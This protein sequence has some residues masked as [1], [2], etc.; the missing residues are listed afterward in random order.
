MMLSRYCSP[1]GSCGLGFTPV[2]SGSRGANSEVNR[3]MQQ[4]QDEYAA[5]FCGLLERA[6]VPYHILELYIP[7]SIG[8]ALPWYDLIVTFPVGVGEPGVMINGF[9]ND[10]LVPPEQ[11]FK[12]KF[13]G[14]TPAEFAQKWPTYCADHRAT[15]EATW[16]KGFGGNDPLAYYDSFTYDVKLGADGLSGVLNPI[17]TSHAP[18]DI[19]P[20]PRTF[21]RSVAGGTGRG[22]CFVATGTPATRTVAPAIPVTTYNLQPGQRS[23]SHTQPSSS[24]NGGASATPTEIVSGGT[25]PEQAS[26]WDRLVSTFTGNG[27]SVSAPAASGL[28][29]IPTWAWVAGAAAVLYFMSGRNKS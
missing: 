3:I 21:F 23:S 15:L 19:V 7:A 17:D 26:T 25:P 10:G 8:N 11:L 6:G 4:N 2:P 24:A 13:G 14:W 18:V 16:S 12:V 1:V 5:L 22:S 28:S 9:A 20:P 29:A 27:E